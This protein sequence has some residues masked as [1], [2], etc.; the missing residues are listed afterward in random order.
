MNVDA[1]NRRN[2]EMETPLQGG[3]PAEH[4]FKPKPLTAGQNI[5]LTLKIMG[6][7]AILGLLLWLLERSNS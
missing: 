7:A 1:E 5:V 2:S 3:E 4:D 6:G